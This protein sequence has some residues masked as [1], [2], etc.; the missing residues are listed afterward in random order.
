MKSPTVASLKKVTPENLAGLGAERLAAILV[1]VANTRPELKRRLRMELAAE[2]GADHLAVEIDRR[3]A[4][5]ESSRSRVSWR[6]RPTF[7]RDLEGLR[8]LIAVRLAGLDQTGALDR[9]W[10][11]MGLARRLGARVRDKDGELG[12][13]F[14]R[15]AADIG[16]LAAGAGDARHAEALVEAMIDN[17]PAWAEWLPVVLGGGP[18]AF[19][20]AALRL[21]SQRAGASPGLVP[22]IRQLADAAV[23]VDAFQSTYPPGALLTPTVAAEVAKRL[24]AVGRLNEAGQVL[25][26]AGPAQ[27]QTKG[28]KANRARG[29]EPDYD[30]ETVWIDYLDQSG[31]SKTAQATRWASFERTLS[32]DR[33]R[34][35][36][37]RLADFDDVEAEGR[38]FAYAA[39]HADF[40]R[41]LRFL[42]EWPA[43][44][45]AAR[46]I[47]ARAEEVRIADEQAELWARQL[48]TR[49]P[50]AA[51]TLLRKAA[52]GA[53]RRG[54]LATCNRL[55]V[56]ADA[57]ELG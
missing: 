27:A 32:A 54:E 42:M 25:E 39:G 18:L 28:A 45:E 1:A 43:L 24:L 41:G 6:H 14:V 9:L 33:A 4:T 5:L 21:M 13:V 50:E 53:F 29:A 7:V 57:I 10:P 30:W 44:P 55:T 2:Q 52:A 47:E 48:R 56:E 35:F 40:E 34:D 8:V 31:Q 17:P 26:A 23:D 38:A 49:Q 3:L 12:A 51:H 46:T 11:F 22:L 36:T 16:R 15:A 37:R 19:A 20:E